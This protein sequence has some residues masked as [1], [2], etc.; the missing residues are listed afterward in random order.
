MARKVAGRRKRQQIDAE[1]ARKLGARAV[2]VA[3][4]AW[5]AAYYIVLYFHL[6]AIRAHLSGP[7][8]GTF[9]L[10]AFVAVT[11]LGLKMGMVVGFARLL[12][13]PK[14]WFSILLNSTLY[15]VMF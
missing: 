8:L 14:A 12:D 5:M 15:L 3:V 11:S 6:N 9:A 10:Y 13:V 7:H 4:I 2:S 1:R